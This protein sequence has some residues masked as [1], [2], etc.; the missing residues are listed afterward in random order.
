MKGTGLEEAEIKGHYLI[1][2]WAE[3]TNLKAPKGPSSGPAGRVLPRA[4]RQH[5]ER[6]P[7]QPE[8]LGSPDA[9]SDASTCAPRGSPGPARPARSTASG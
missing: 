1:L 6:Q 8:L 7:D 4:G 9:Q 2:T 3:F 5:R